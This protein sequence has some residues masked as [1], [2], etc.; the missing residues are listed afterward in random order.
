MDGALGMPLGMH[1]SLNR[2]LFCRHR[3]STWKWAKDR[4]A[5][6]A[7]WTWLHAQVSD[8]EYRIRQ[9]SEL[10]R[11][12]RANKGAVVL[13]PS[14]HQQHQNAAAIANSL[15]QAVSPPRRGNE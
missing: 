7:R 15:L 3:R 4:A 5:V 11:N 10:Y 6:A 13:G 2:S 12:I 14:L 9:M 1:S 8:L